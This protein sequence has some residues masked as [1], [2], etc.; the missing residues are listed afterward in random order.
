M[1][2]NLEDSSYVIVGF[3]YDGTSTYRRGARFGPREIRKASLNIETYSFRTGIYLESVNLCDLGDVKTKGG[4]RQ[5]ID[6]T[7]Q[8]A[9]SI[10]SK[11]KILVSIG[12]EHTLTYGV[13]KGLPKDTALI[14][15][16]AHFDLRNEYAKKILS[17]AT[18]MRRIAEQ[19]GPEKLFFIGTRAICKEEMEF[20]KDNDIRFISSRQLLDQD[21]RNQVRRINR[22]LNDYE[23]YYITLDMD[24][25]DPSQAPGVGNP[26]PE[27]IQVSR[28]LDILQT[29][30]GE[31]LLGIDL[32]EVAP[33]QNDD[34][35]AIEA[36]RIIF[37][38]ICFIEAGKRPDP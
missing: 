14:S 11:N 23:K 26:E 30:C 18:F 37:E 8:I 7:S 12:G 16:D 10:F 17:H 28:L 25:L 21:W 1:V 4:L 34:I 5:A 38:T 36:A 24:V 19:I 29:I 31:R 6:A 35:T 2:S 13:S 33:N 3:P 20:V 9:S 32:T 15:F 27:G 22:F